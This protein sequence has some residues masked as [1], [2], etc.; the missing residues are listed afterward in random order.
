MAVDQH[1]FLSGFF[2]FFFIVCNIGLKKMD[3]DDLT[4]HRHETDDFSKWCIFFYSNFKCASFFYSAVSQRQSSVK[5]VH[6]YCWI[7]L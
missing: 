5:S 7:Q 6:A 4:W 3:L 1:L 2:F